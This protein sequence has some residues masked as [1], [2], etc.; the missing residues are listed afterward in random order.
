MEEAVPV[1]VKHAQM[2]VDLVGRQLGPSAWLQVTQANV[3]AF[4][5]AVDDVHGP[6]TTPSALPRACSEV[7]SLTP[8]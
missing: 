8:T 1:H 5:R 4:G 6:T 7:R 2:L 3:D